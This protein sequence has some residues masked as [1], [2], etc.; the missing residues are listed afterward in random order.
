M[1]L[2]II[3]QSGDFSTCA[4]I[5]E[6][7]IAEIAALGFKTLINNRPDGEGGAE[8]P[9]SDRIKA[10]AEQAGLAY[11]YLPV[12]PWNITNEDAAAC[13]RIMADAPGPILAFCRT[14][15][16]SGKLYQMAKGL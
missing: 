4:Q 9:A 16:R 6:A 1:G 15:A 3:Q 12:V 5:T 2:E 11:V 14:G 13:S 10:A 7:D 8:Q